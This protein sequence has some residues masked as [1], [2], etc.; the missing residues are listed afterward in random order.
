MATRTAGLRRLLKLADF[1]DAL[2]PARFDYG[3]W[4]RSDWQGSS[5]LSC[6]TAACALGWA[7]TIPEFRKMGLRLVRRFKSGVP[8]YKSREGASAAAAFFGVTDEEAFYLFVRNVHKTR[9]R[10]KSPGRFA[11]LS[12]TTR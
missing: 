7:T 10:S 2:P 5:D 11:G 12:P 1:L 8:V 4:V 6:G 9:P 3:V